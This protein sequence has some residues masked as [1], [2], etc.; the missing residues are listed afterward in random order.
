MIQL[1]YKSNLTRISISL[2]LMSEW[3]PDSSFNSIILRDEMEL[4]CS[5]NNAL[6]SLRDDDGGNSRLK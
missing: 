1:I 5:N 4:Y 6:I 3:N 2:Y